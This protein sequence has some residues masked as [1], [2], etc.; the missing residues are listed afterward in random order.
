MASTIRGKFIT[1]ILQLIV[2]KNHARTL[3]IR[4]ND[5]TADILASKVVLSTQQK[6]Y[7]HQPIEDFLDLEVDTKGDVTH[8]KAI[9]VPTGRENKLVKVDDGSKACTLCRLN[10]KNLNYTDVK[11]LGQYIKRDHS[12]ASLEESKLCSKQ[13]RKIKNLIKQ[14]QR[15]NLIQRP[16]DYLVP[17]YWH[18]L[19]TYLEPD[20][21]RDQPM[22]VIKTQYWKI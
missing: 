18:D 14:A 13:Y 9:P 21:R 11:I 16:A 8:V 10:L 20:R 12:L 6:R 19:N 3:A 5:R 15:C 17:G 4:A 7:N 1:N 22:K 2:H